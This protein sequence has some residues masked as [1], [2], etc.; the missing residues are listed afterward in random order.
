MNFFDY[1][2]V[3]YLVIINLIGF[4]IMGVDKSKAKKGAWRIPE[5]AFF[6]VSLL[7]GGLGSWIGMYTYRH[8]TKHWYFVVG[9]PAIFLVELVGLIYLYGRI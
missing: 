8:K 6:I 4:I 2:V 9:I 7:G 3:T 5:K 1:V